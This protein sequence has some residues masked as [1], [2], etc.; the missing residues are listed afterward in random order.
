MEWLSGL[1]L[2]GLF[3]GTFLAATV[4]PFSSDVLFIGI[5]MTDVNPWIVLA[6]GT[7]GN[8]LGGLTSYGVG[9]LGKWEWIEKWFKVKPET[10]EKQKSRIDKWGPPLAL[11]SWLPFVG[12]V[13]AIGL[14]FY[15]VS[16]WKCAGYMLIGKCL[17]F[18]FW[19][20]LFLQYGEAVKQFLF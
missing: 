4:V 15:K 18:A 12:D 9:Y 19:T 7:L 17:R 2:L 16:F 5:L 10:L 14:G 11:I 20:I 13:F 6:V 3:L 1:G 8:W